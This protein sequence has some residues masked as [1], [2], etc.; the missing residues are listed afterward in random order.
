M[1]GQ[2]LVDQCIHHPF[3]YFPSFY[4]IKG[5]LLGHSV[6]DSLERYKTNMREDLIALWKIWVPA[7]FVNFGFSPMWLRIP[8][9]ACVS[10]FWTCLLSMMRGASDTEVSNT[11]GMDYVGNQAHAMIRQKRRPG[12]NPEKDTLVVTAIGNDQV[13]LVHKLSG[14][15]CDQQGNITESKMMRLGQFHRRQ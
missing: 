2:V 5:M 1:I 3:L 4:V 15:V 6:K 13:G 10:L 11:R 12:L 8:F 14:V 7:S 9:V